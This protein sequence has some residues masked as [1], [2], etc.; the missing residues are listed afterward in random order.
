MTNDAVLRLADIAASPGPVAERA[1]E[2]LMELGR[3]IP[4]DASWV[5]LAEPEGTGYTSLASTSLGEGTLRYLRGPKMARDI[6]LTG[7]DRA[8]PPLS[9][10]DLPYPSAELQTWAECLLPSGF[11]EGLGV[12]LFAPGGRHV[13]FLALLFGGAE[14]PP[15]AMRR[16][17]A[18]VLP[19]LAHGVDP[20]RSMATAALLVHGAS[21]GVVLLPT[22]GIS[23]LPG[24]PDDELLT[25]GPELLDA[26]RAA[27]GDGQLYASFL[28]PRGDRRAPGGH[29]H[30]TVMR[31]GDDLRTVLAGVVVLSP[32]KELHGLTPRELQVLGLVIHGCSN[33]EIAHELVVAPRTVAA[34]LEHILVKLQAESRTLAAVRA[35]RA[36]LYVPATRPR[37]DG[38]S[39]QR[40]E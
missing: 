15:I 29:V 13:G 26:A 39:M 4:F 10:S 9:L 12:A 34:H 37:R 35:E 20:V 32:A 24:L 25:A 40:R 6:E 16:R 2:L 38:R 27:I 21:A 28:W 7:T 8:R 19:I 11:H 33:H 17:M 14:P 1:E 18:Q 3:H 31:S 23:P 36:G 5:A 30:V 22:H